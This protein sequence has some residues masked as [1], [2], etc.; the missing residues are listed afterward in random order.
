MNG[1]SFSFSCSFE[2]GAQLACQPPRLPSPTSSM[3]ARSGCAFDVGTAVMYNGASGSRTVWALPHELNTIIPTCVA[4]VYCSV[5]KAVPCRKAVVESYDVEKKT[6]RL[7]IKRRSRVN[8]GVVQRG[9][10]RCTDRRHRFQS[11]HPIVQIAL[12]KHR[13]TTSHVLKAICLR[14]NESVCLF[15]A[16]SIFFIVSVCSCVGY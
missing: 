8:V 14:C 4:A 6:Y 15:F 3:A 2:R 1:H 12:C 7:D 9:G 16:G 11:K 5:W 13:L 10:C